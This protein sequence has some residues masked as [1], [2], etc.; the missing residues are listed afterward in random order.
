M[1]LK[2]YASMNMWKRII[3]FF[4]IPFVIIPFIAGF[5]FMM[6]GLTREMRGAERESVLYKDNVAHSILLTLGDSI[7]GTLNTNIVWSDFYEA[8]ARN[9]VPWIEDNINTLPKV[10]PGIHFCITVNRDYKLVTSVGGVSLDAADL[11]KNKAT[12]NDSFSGLYNTNKGPAIIAAGILRDDNGEGQEKSPGYLVIGKVLNKEELG[13]IKAILNNDITIWSPGGGLWGTSATNLAE[14]SIKP[15]WEN[16]LQ[17]NEP[18][19]TNEKIGGKLKYYSFSALKDINNKPIGLISLESP[20]LNMTEKINA[21]ITTGIIFIVI[22]FSLTIFLL[23]KRIQKPVLEIIKNTR[24]YATGDFTGKIDIN[25]RDEMGTLAR[26]VNDMADSLRMLIEGIVNSSRVLSGESQGLAASSEEI[27]ASIQQLAATAEEMA[28]ISESTRLKVNAAVDKADYVKMVASGGQ[29][30]MADTVSKMEIIKKSSMTIAGAVNILGEYSKQIGRITEVITTLAEQTNLLS[31]NAAIEAAR[32]G[33]HGRGFAVVADE[34]HQLAEQS[35]KAAKDI[36]VLISNISLEID[37]A[38]NAME[39]GAR[40]V[41]AGVEIAEKTRRDVETI[42]NSILVVVEKID[43]LSAGAEE[44][45][46]RTKQLSLANEQIKQS[47]LQIAAMTQNMSDVSQ[48]LIESVSK[49]KTDS[50]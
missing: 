34:V 32:A 14:N 48:T 45:S 23:K 40:E 35:N 5:Y 44:S 49:F 2:N 50:I 46:E 18:V 4:M 36:A 21:Y 8:L 28:G 22:V 47:M 19:I 31:L 10:S 15:I 39:V 41:N 29:Q 3:L 12:K 43:E 26:S 13:N 6:S 1:M 20:A 7:T 17:R 30:Q 27:S 37:N 11:L 25:S 38:V 16:V 33:E 9:D 24:R 42:F